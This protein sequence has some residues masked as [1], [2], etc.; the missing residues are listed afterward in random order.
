MKKVL[1]IIMTLF[2]GGMTVFCLVN[3]AETLS[4]SE[5]REL[6]Q[7]PELTLKSLVSGRF[8]EKFEEYAADQF[9]VR[10]GWRTLKAQIVFDVL[11]QKDNNEL[12]VKGGHI[13]KIEYPL[14][15]ASVE[16][17]A[18]IF[19]RIQEEQ[20]ASKN[21]R[22]FYSVIP[23]KNYFLGEN[24]LRLDYEKMLSILEKNLTKMEYIDIF[25]QLEVEDYYKTDTHWRQE[26]L[27]D[28]AE[29]LASGMD[30]DV[31]AEYEEILL[32]EPFYGVYYGQ[33]GVEKEPDK[34]TYLTNETLESCTVFD[35]QNEKATTIYDLKKVGGKDAYEMFLSGSVSLMEI[36]NPNAKTEKKLVVF[37][38]SFG[39]AI[40]PLLVE[41]YR[42]ITLADI[43]Y[44]SSKYIEQFVDFERADVLFLYSTSV[45]NHSEILK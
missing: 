38:D 41:G 32:K 28:V 43:R 10:D 12:Y 26:K 13:A 34:L 31:A 22:V 7:F 40:A 33:L 29:K 9:P 27:I 4:E 35:Y 2:L 18:T 15:E 14:N 19:N 23:D 30:A 45:L 36:E 16:R 24:H 3:P 11:Q 20:L 8:M 5:R 39:S 25:E 6:Q 1:V 17:A 44:I 42:K 37:R 21:C